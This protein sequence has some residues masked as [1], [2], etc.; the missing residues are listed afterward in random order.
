MHN[1]IT[2]NKLP[3][4][5]FQKLINQRVGY[6][7]E[8]WI[9]FIIYWFF[10]QQQEVNTPTVS[11]LTQ[12]AVFAENVRT[13]MLFLNLQLLQIDYENHPELI[14]AAQNIGN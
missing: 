2:K 1:T 4:F 9:K 14:I 7:L 6:F 12:L 11:D 5:L 8:L 3:K 13:T 10:L